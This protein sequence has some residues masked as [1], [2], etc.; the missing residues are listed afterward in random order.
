MLLTEYL[1]NKNNN[2]AIDKDLSLSISTRRGTFRN[3]LDYLMD[4][5]TLDFRVS[6][7]KEGEVI[8]S[9]FFIKRYMKN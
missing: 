8:Y 1:L 5:P 7:L 2:I 6:I 3:Q 4:I 9:T